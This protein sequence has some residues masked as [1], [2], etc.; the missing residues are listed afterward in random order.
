M[1]AALEQHPRLTQYTI[2]IA[3]DLTDRS[4]KVGKGKTGWEHWT[5]HKSKWEQC[6][7]AK[8]MAVEFLP[9]TKSEL[10]DRLVASMANRG[11]VLFWFNAR[12][13]DEVWFQKLFERAK[14]DLGERFQPEDHVEVML[15]RAFN[16]LAR[17][18]TYLS[19]LSEWFCEIP[20]LENLSSALSKLNFPFEERFV[21]LEA[22]CAALRRI[23]ES[24]HGFEARPFPIAD[25]QHAIRSVS[26]AI[27]PLREWLYSQETEGN[28]TTKSARRDA[29]KCLDKISSHLGRAPIHI[30]ANN[31]HETRIEADLRRVLVVVGEAGSGKS[32]LFADTVATSLNKRV[33]AILLLGQYFSEHD[34]RREFLHRLDHANHDFET[35]LQAL[36]VAGEAAQSRLIILIDALNEAHALRVWLDQLAGFVSDILQHEWLAIGVSLRPEYEHRLLPETVRNEAAREICQGIQS[37][38]EQE[39]AASQYFVKRGITRPAVPWLAPEFSNF[40]FL[41]TCC[42]A[43]QDRGIHEFPR[44]LRGSLKVLEFYLDSLDS[45]LRRRFP[46]RD[47]PT[48]AMRNSIRR[49]AKTMAE[50]RTDYINVKLGTEICE[51]EFGCQGPHAEPRWFS[52][53]ISEGLLRRDHIFHDNHDAPLAHVKDVYRFTYQHFSDHLIVQ[54]L[55]ERVD[56]IGDAFKMGGSLH[57]LVENDDLWAWSSLWS[58]LAVQIPEK[59][60]GKELLDVLPDEIDRPRNHYLSLRHSNTVFSGGPTRL[61]RIE[62]SSYSTR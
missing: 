35:V 61:F 37:P 42:D 13:F 53:L 7:R 49:I 38:E 4:G 36:N 32:H 47:F 16:G 26:D 59:F 46:S 14:A 44:G 3:C 56:D 18:S 1:K 25:W 24:I 27:S 33:P 17:S 23:G 58:A 34:I 12:L 22:Q 41:K 20:R 19:F 48:S 51:G 39:Q 55:L 43:L 6:A 30:G 2:A 57:F 29:S 21:H 54:A 9:W 60:A 11:L 50:A 8:G 15:A 28:E 5:T 52:V 10:T 45:K 62:R 40:L 31:S